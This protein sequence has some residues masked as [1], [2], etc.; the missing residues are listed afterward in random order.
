MYYFFCEPAGPTT[1][2][3]SSRASAERAQSETVGSDRGEVD[4]TWRHCVG[5]ARRRHL[6]LDHQSWDQ[7]I[8][9]S[10]EANGGGSYSQ[11]WRGSQENGAERYDTE[12]RFGGAGGALCCRRSPIAV[13]QIGRASCRER[14]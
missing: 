11:A 13:A 7:G 10:P 12:G 8:R 2:V 1:E 5:G 3:L 14:G 4:R 6:S 9:I